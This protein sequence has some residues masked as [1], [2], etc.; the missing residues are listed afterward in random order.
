M[1]NSLAQSVRV[2]SLHFQRETV[3]IFKSSIAR[4][5]SAREFYFLDNITERTFTGPSMVV[6]LCLIGFGTVL[7]AWSGQSAE[8]DRNV[9]RKQ[10]S[11]RKGRR[12]REEDEEETRR[13][14]RENRRSRNRWWLCAYP[15]FGVL[16]KEV[17]H[18]QVSVTGNPTYRLDV[19]S[20]SKSQKK[21]IFVSKQPPERGPRFISLLVCQSPR[22]SRL[23]ATVVVAV[24]R[25]RGRGAKKRKREAIPASNTKLQS[26]L[27]FIFHRRRRRYAI[28]ASWMRVR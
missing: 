25:W 28:V 4:S 26:A 17:F 3:A 22:S 9:V 27:L 1:M 5:R 7:T 10:C 18:L 6:G 15:L 14:G 16:E 24:S 2:S 21:P 8:P 19:T 11:E 20:G 23:V 13:E 12:R